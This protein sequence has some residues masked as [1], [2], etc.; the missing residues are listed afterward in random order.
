VQLRRNEVKRLPDGREELS[1]L[2]KNVSSVNA[3]A[4]VVVNYL[5]AN[6]DTIGVRTLELKDIKPGTVQKFALEFQCPE[7]LAVKKRDIDI[8]ELTEAE[9]VAAA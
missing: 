5:D 6:E 7:G 9:A 1:G 2:V 8:G 4:I 3:D